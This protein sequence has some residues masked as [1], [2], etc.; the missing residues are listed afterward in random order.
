MTFDEEEEDASVEAEED[1]R[2]AAPPRRRRGVSPAPAEGRLG[3]EPVWSDRCLFRL[4]AAQ[5][6]QLPT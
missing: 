4:D 3:P 5:R 1:A 2:A 6:Q